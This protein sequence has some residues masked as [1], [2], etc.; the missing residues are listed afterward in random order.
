MVLIDETER[1]VKMTTAPGYDYAPTRQ[2][3]ES[4]ESSGTTEPTLRTVGGSITLAIKQ[5]CQLFLPSY[6]SFCEKY[7]P[8]I[9][10]CVMGGFTLTSSYTPNFGNFIASCTIGA[11][12]GRYMAY[13]IPASVIFWIA[14]ENIKYK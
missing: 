7:G 3:P 4:P 6:L 12:A 1:A 10:F 13:L 8:A 5:T 2:P 9:G 11:M 14:R